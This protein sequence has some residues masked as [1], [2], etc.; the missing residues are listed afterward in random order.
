M[1]PSCCYTSTIKKDAIGSRDGGISSSQT[2]TSNHACCLDWAVVANYDLMFG[3]SL[4]Y[5]FMW[6]RA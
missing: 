1:L 3:A 4:L 6:L 5:M 2:F